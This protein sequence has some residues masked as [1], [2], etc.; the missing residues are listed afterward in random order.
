MENVKKF[1]LINV[2]VSNLIMYS[3]QTL[4]MIFIIYTYI[5]Y[6]FMVRVVPSVIFLLS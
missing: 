3:K 2:T 5:G 6:C 1:K 4:L